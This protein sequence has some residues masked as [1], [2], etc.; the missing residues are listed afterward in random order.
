MKKIILIFL[1]VC[2]ATIFGFA[3]CQTVRDTNSSTKISTQSSI[4]NSKE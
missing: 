3:G 2:M 4:S 1:M